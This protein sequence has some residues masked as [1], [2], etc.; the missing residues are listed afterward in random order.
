[1][2]QCGVSPFELRVFG[3][4][5]KGLFGFRMGRRCF[6]FKVSD[7]YV[8]CYTSLTLSSSGSML[9]VTDGAGYDF[10][11]VASK[12]AERCPPDS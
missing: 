5:A 10:C 3:F 1:M 2:G 7:G 4:G 9:P 11:V 6:G 12:C 8:T